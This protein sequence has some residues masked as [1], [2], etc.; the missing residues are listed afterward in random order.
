[1][2]SKTD[3]AFHRHN[4]AT[5]F[6]HLS[7]AAYA[8]EYALN[9]NTARVRLAGALAALSGESGAGAATETDQGSKG[10]KAKAGKGSSKSDHPKSDRSQ[11]DPGKRDRSASDRS[12]QAAATPKTKKTPSTPNRYKH[13]RPGG[14]STA[15]RGGGK[16]EL[17]QDFAFPALGNEFP[18]DHAGGWVSL[19][20]LDEDIQ[21]AAFS[22]S[23]GIGGTMQL[24]I[25][26]YLQMRR[27]Q[28]EMIQDIEADY[29][30]GVSWMME[31]GVPMPRSVAMSQAHFGPGQRMAELESVIT[32]MQAMA[33]NEHP[34]TRAEQV[35][36]IEK[37]M[38]HREE[39]DLTAIETA[40]LLERKGIEVPRA[41]LAEVSREVAMIEPPVDTEG[42]VTDEELE[43]MARKY[44][45]KLDYQRGGWVDARREQVE[46]MLAKEAANQQSDQLEEGDFAAEL[47]RMDEERDEPPL[48]PEQDVEEDWG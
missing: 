26:R 32:R 35:C 13:G 31:G 18:R 27:L 24:A 43:V 23:Q 10:G 6:S 1:M 16:R 34:M 48:T 2:S 8:R 25:G 21:E 17:I 11:I 46:D 38:L 44:R 36:Y 30:N 12:E 5:A 37:V 28:S 19:L 33:A 14:E 9:P 4:Y 7:T 22:L 15:E 29:S 20:K 41:L 42:G 3:W 40:R 39:C 47:A 45:E